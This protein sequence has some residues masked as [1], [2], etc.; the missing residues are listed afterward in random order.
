[1]IF[2]IQTLPNITNLFRV[3]VCSK[4]GISTQD[5]SSVQNYLM[6]KGFTVTNIPANGAYIETIGSVAKIQQ[7][8]N[9]QINNYLTKNG[10]VVYSNDRAITLDQEINDKVSFITGFRQYIKNAP[11]VRG[12]WC[13]TQ[14]SR[15]ARQWFHN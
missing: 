11:S 5:V 14:C 15:N 2:I 10:K 8:F 7:T 9:T 4:F 6:N 3:L 1:M 12:Y 13:I